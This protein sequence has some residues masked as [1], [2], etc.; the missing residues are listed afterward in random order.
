MRDVAVH[1]QVIE[2]HFNYSC[3]Y[4][5]NIPC[6][7]TLLT[8]LAKIASH[9]ALL[10]YDPQAMQNTARQAKQQE[11]K[12]FAEEVVVTTITITI[13]TFFSIIGG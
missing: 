3:S 13:I 12:R 10:Q 7:F 6:L 4:D 5:R 11:I 1:E 2:F 8:R 9:P